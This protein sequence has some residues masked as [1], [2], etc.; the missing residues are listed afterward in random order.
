MIAGGVDSKVYSSF[1][2]PPVL[3]LVPATAR[4]V[5]DLGCGTGE[6]AMYLKKRGT[7]VDGVTLSESEARIAKKYCRNV[8]V[9][10]LEEGLPDLSGEVYDCVIC[11]HVLE[12][13]RFPNKLLHDI[14][15]ILSEEGRLVVALPNLM[16]FKS[17]YNLLMGKFDYQE[18]GLMDNTH[19]RW[20]TFKTAQKLLEEHGYVNVRSFAD[21]NFPVPL[22]RGLL[23]QGAFAW[24]DRW[25]CRMVPTLFGSQMRFLC[26]KSI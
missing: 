26:S 21:G 11:S 24:M 18:E 8:Y 20:Y 9:Y 19:F 15:T 13:I 16:Y 22:L 12:H 3:D 7:L 4:K 17:R 6:H 23:P 14:K 2:N 25:A 1:L 5:L 10:D